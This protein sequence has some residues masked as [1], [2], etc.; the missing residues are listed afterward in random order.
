VLLLA[1]RMP[2]STLATSRG[3]SRAGMCTKVKDMAEGGG[4]PRLARLGAASLPLTDVLNRRRRLYIFVLRIIY[5]LNIFVYDLHC[6]I[7]G[8]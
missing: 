4:A 6:I 8:G 3:D 2:C 7:L 5:T 1:N